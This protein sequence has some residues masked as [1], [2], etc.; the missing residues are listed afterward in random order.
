MIGEVRYRMPGDGGGL[1]VAP[2]AIRWPTLP[3]NGV[4]APVAVRA[5]NTRSSPLTVSS[6]ALERS[7]TWRSATT[8]APAGRL[9]RTRVARCG[10]GSR[11]R[12]RADEGRLRIFE[13]SGVGH[14]TDFSANVVP[15]TA[16]FT[17]GRAS[18]ERPW[19]VGRRSS[20]SRATPVTTSVRASPGLTTRGTPPSSSSTPGTTSSMRTSSATTA[21]TGPFWFT[22]P[23]GD[24]LAPGYVYDEARRAG[25]S[26]MQGWTSP[27]TP[28]CNAVTGSFAVHSLRIDDFGNPVSL[29]VT[30]EHHCEGG[31]PGLRGTFS[32]QHP[33]P[34][35]TPE[36]FTPPTGD[37][38]L[39][40]LVTITIRD[41]RAG[42]VVKV[43]EGTAC[44]AGVPVK[45]QRKVDSRFRTVATLTTDGSG[46][47]G[48]WIG[49]RYGIYRAVIPR[50]ELTDGT[51]CFARP[52][53]ELEILSATGRSVSRGARARH[54]VESSEV[55][56]RK[57]ERRS[58]DVLLQVAQPFGTWVEAHAHLE[59][60]SRRSRPAPAWRRDA[61]PLGARPKRSPGWS[62]WLRP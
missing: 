29:R 51:V 5:V 11:R 14:L 31:D 26:V 28:G 46:R 23:L 27:G 32:W 4:A 15:E 39:A 7:P 40:R 17:P 38:G 45:L 21:R 49:T 44:R 22:P 13:P 8:S 52:V 48:K 3:I 20:A 24:I 57:H 10:C 54:N 37:A 6:A 33:G 25:F 34:L 30:F 60:A 59:R 61:R 19:E 1:M 12:A 43:E 55:V 42:G 50:V 41:R 35:A 16:P 47:Y 56:P 53:A 62:R 2:R 9:R 58:P 18:R 36:Q